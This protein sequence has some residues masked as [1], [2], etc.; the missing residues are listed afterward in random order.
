MYIFFFPSLVVWLLT[1]SDG[2]Q[3]R[4]NSSSLPSTM[5]FKIILCI[6]LVKKMVFQNWNYFIIVERSSELLNL[7]VAGGA[8]VLTHLNL[9]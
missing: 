3:S 4:F 9:L 7:N 2:F 8:V 5:K 1:P 6:F